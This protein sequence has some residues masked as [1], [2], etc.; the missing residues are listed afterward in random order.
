MVTLETLVK[1]IA[2]QPP[3]LRPTLKSKDKVLKKILP[4]GTE[5]KGFLS[6]INEV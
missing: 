3:H 6:I 5:W 4:R 2:D 1:R